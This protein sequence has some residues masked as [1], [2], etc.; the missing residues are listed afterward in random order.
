[1]GGHPSVALATHLPVARSA[2][3][4]TLAPVTTSPTSSH[5]HIFPGVKAA[6]VAA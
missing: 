6:S 1:M 3:W 5:A 2:W 4:H